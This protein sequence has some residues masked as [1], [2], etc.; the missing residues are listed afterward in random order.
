MIWTTEAL[1]RAYTS[2]AG[3]LLAAASGLG[4]ALAGWARAELSA[5]GG[6]VGPAGWLA[7]PMPHA[8]IVRVHANQPHRSLIEARV[9]CM[10]NLQR[11]RGG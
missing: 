11:A 10:C 8:T 3:F 7:A 9:I 2:A 1:L 6:G 4:C 5:D